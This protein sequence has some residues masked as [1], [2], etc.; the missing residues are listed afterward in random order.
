M[1]HPDIIELFA[2]L[3]M[4]D[5]I[6]ETPAVEVQSTPYNYNNFWCQ[7]REKIA[8]S[9]SLIHNGHYIAATFSAFLCTIT[10]HLSSIPW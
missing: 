8:S 5:E 3:E 2:Y 9:M 6:K 4:H 1:I 7:G 10:A